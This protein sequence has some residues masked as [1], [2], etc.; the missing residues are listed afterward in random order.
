MSLK[1]IVVIGA[2]AGGPRILKNVFTGLPALKC[3]IVLI[4]HMPQFINESLI[5]TISECTDMDVQL[6][7]DGQILKDGC[8]YVI[9][10]EV[11]AEVVQNR[12][13]RLFKG[14][15][16]NYV[17]PAVD[18]TMESLRKETGVQHIGI[19]LT[20]M[21]R[22]GAKG[23]CHIKAIGGMTIAQDEKSSII[24][25]M[26]KEAIETGCIDLILSPEEINEKLRQ[27]IDVL[28]VS[29]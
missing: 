21:G 11:H 19:V 18:V 14:D 4:Q 9:P 12:S 23:I 22:D 6:A 25:G 26:P 2:S 13:L 3:S 10:S 20:G 8:V 28:P 17:C 24:F 15:P 5:Q 29:L 7:V 1:M 16:V 27:I